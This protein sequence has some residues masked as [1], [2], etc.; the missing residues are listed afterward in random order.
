MFLKELKAFVLTMGVVVLLGLAVLFGCYQIM[1]HK[2]SEAD[3]LAQ[4]KSGAFDKATHFLWRN[5]EAF[6]AHYRETQIKS[7]HAAGLMRFVA[8]YMT[9]TTP[10]LEVMANHPDLKYITLLKDESGEELCFEFEIQEGTYRRPL[11]LCYA[12]DER[13]TPMPIAPLGENSSKPRWYEWLGTRK[14]TLWT[15]FFSW[16]E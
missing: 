10:D 7:V 13:W 2:T 14:A 11:Y 9:E 16:L 5:R 8:D 4:A 6:N 1:I 15:K 3:I 12:E